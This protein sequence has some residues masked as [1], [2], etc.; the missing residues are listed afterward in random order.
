MKGSALVAW[1]FQMTGR[2]LKEHHQGDKLRFYLGPGITEGWG[3][4]FEVCLRVSLSESYNST[5]RY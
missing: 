3:G 2:L 4:R 1:S 5:E